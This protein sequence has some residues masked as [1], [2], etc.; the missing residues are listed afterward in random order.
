MTTHSVKPDAGRV[1]SC[2][3]VTF[4]LLDG[5]SWLRQKVQPLNTASRFQVP[6]YNNYLQE[7]TFLFHGQAY[8]KSFLFHTLQLWLLNHSQAHNNKSLASR[9]KSWELPQVKSKIFFP[10]NLACNIAVTVKIESFSRQLFIQHAVLSAKKEEPPPSVIVLRNHPF[11][12]ALAQVKF[13]ENWFHKVCISKLLR[14]QPSLFLFISPP[15]PS[16]GHPFSSNAQRLLVKGHAVTWLAFPLQN[17]SSVTAQ[18][19]P[20]RLH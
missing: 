18:R 4:P 7:I 14:L 15:P 17:F 16:S 12:C 1:K 5:S 3:D 11:N 9:N 19:W 10:E 20:S 2:I 8:L 13:C 6:L